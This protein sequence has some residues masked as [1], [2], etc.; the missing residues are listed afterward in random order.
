M[1]TETLC[2]PAAQHAHETTH[3]MTSAE[4]RTMTVAAVSATMML[5]EIIGGELLG[6]MAVTAD[7]LHMAS[8]TLALGIAAFAY[9]YAR[10]H[11]LNPRFAFGTGKVNA[12][13]GYTGAAFLGVTALWMLWES[14]ARAWSPADIHYGE[15]MSIAALGLGVNAW[16]A[17]LLRDDHGAHAHHGPACRHDADYNLRAAYLH[18]VSDAATSVLAIVALAAAWRWNVPQL[19]AIAGIAAACVVDWLWVVLV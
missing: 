15:A 16:S 18:V 17:W 13:G 19:D 5:V 1:P 4:R 7:G 6:S 3:R 10:R 8:H 2:T 14:V 9:V 12:L 11:A